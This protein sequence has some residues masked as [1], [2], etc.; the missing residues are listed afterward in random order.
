MRTLSQRRKIARATAQTVM[1]RLEEKGWLQH[2]NVGQAFFYS[3][4]FGREAT[5]GRLIRDLVDSAFGG[6]AESMVWAL[7]QGRGISNKEAERIQ[8]MIDEAEQNKP[9]ARKKR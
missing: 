2:R 7:L 1:T 9:K 8:Q 6:A 3:A 5:Q 4:V